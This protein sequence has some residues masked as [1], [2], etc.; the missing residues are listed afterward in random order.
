MFLPHCAST[1]LRMESP[2]N[3]SLN[4]AF[5]FYGGDNVA[6]TREEVQQ[7]LAYYRNIVNTVRE[8]LII[9]DK[10]LK[11]VSANDAFYRIFHAAKEETEHRL[12]YELGNGQWNIDGLK[13]VL[14]EI[15]SAS[16]H[17]QDYIVDH[18]F[19]VIGHKVMLLN[20]RC[21]RHEED[22]AQFILLAIE[23]ITERREVEEEL[24]RGEE[25][26][27]AL[28]NASSNAIYRMSPDW[29]EMLFLKGRD[30]I[31]DTN[32]PSETWVQKNIPPGEQTRVQ[33]RIDRAIRTKSVFELE[34]RVLRV[35]GTL[36]WAFSRA[37][38]LLDADGRIIEWFGIAT[39]ITGRKKTEEDLAAAKR[40]AE[41]RAEEAEQ[42][43]NILNALMQFV[44]VEL[45]IIDSDRTIIRDSRFSEK[46]TGHPVEEVEGLSLEERNKKIP[47]Y[48]PDGVTLARVDELPAVRVLRTGEAV[49]NEEWKVK[50]AEGRFVDVAINSGPIRDSRG[51]VTGAVTTWH[52]ITGIKKAE[53]TLR[54]NEYELRTVVDNSPDIFFRMDRQMRY[55]YVNPTYERITGIAK[56][57][58]IGRTNE[59]LA[60]TRQLAG[61]WRSAVQDVLESG[62]EGSVEFDLSGFF[63]T[64]YFSARIIPEF[65]KAGLVETVL[66]IARDITERKHAE[67]EIDAL[68]R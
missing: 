3:D 22:A 11:V 23:D 42:G 24:R 38:P 60:M 2:S 21:V 45:Q 56:E 31:P 50:T 34:H 39:D 19:P 1:P 41:K 65:D 15:V 36:G 25:R 58:F 18:E 26:L 43:R 48:H 6:K 49:M 17:F 9:L 27:R 40:N 57:R 46:M 30:F 10:D 54:R 20:G 7:A 28:V 53:E 63:G 5:S 29:K 67:E 44:P 66:V 62:R 51:V 68:K 16:E 14:K 64:R 32:N 59:Q 55:S 47:F 61:L 8:A 12:I 33:E 35:D 13:E 37:V 52:D 4:A